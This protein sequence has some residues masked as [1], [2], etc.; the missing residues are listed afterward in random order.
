M[1]GLLCKKGFQSRIPSSPVIFFM[2]LRKNVCTFCTKFA[3]GVVTL[4]SQ[5]DH[6]KEVTARDLADECRAVCAVR[7][8]ANSENG[9]TN[10]T[11]KTSA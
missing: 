3:Q 9:Q 4:A 5:S 10:T 11:L 7:N 6:C 1:P 8:A 2:I